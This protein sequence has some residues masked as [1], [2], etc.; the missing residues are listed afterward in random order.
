MIEEA[1]ECEEDL[2]DELSKQMTE[3]RVSLPTS[4][5]SKKTYSTNHENAAQ[6]SGLV[7]NPVEGDALES[8]PLNSKTNDPSTDALPFELPSLVPSDQPKPPQ[9][10]AKTD[11]SPPRTPLQQPTGHNEDSNSP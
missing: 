1:D 8:S 7:L 6:E 2:D 11:T 4:Q 9:N 5:N 10:A 3:P